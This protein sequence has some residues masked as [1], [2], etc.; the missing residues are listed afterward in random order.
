MSVEWKYA[1][2]YHRD[3][4]HVVLYQESFWV[5]AMTQA[6]DSKPI[7]FAVGYIPGA[8]ALFS[9]LALWLD[10]KEDVIV[11]IPATPE[12]LAKIAPDDEWLWGETE[13]DDEH[14]NAGDISAG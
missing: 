2:W 6:L 8:Y 10:K 3:G 1:V 5:T 7:Q 14:N 11:R 13:D 4:D 12:L 9:K